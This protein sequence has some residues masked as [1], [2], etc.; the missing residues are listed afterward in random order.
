MDTI[1]TSSDTDDTCLRI[2]ELLSR[3]SPDPSTKVGAL[4][5]RNYKIIG[6]GYNNF[7]QNTNQDPLLWADREEKY[8]RVVHA[9]QNA[10]IGINARNA[11]LYTTMFPCSTCCGV[12]INA[13]IIQ[14]NTFLIPEAFALRWNMSIES[15]RSMLRSS[16]VEVKFH[17]VP[18]ALVR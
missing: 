17:L 1:S 2:C 8:R 5:L 10:L 3:S 15:S 7:P 6:S 12:I 13:G 16:G 14:I 9:E 4:V 18:S 11:I